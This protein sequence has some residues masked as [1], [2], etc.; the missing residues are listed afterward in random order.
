VRNRTQAEIR[1]LAKVLL[2]SVGA[3]GDEQA[4][5]DTNG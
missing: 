2:A 5:G 3:G 1:R 4:A